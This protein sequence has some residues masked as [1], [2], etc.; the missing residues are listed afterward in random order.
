MDPKKAKKQAHESF[1]L[2]QFTRVSAS[3]PRKFFG[4]SVRAGHFVEM[5]VHRAEKVSD[6]SHISYFARKALINLRLSPNQFSELLTTMNVGMGVPC[7]LQRVAGVD[8][9][10][11]VD[12]DN[13]RELHHKDFMKEIETATKEIREAI[14]EAGEALKTSKASFGIGQRK[15]LLKKLKHVLMRLESNLPYYHSKFDESVDK[16]IGEAKA[17]IDTFAGNVITQLGLDSLET[18]KAIQNTRPDLKAITDGK[19]DEGS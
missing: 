1:G 13:I 4:S 15:E 7:T 9:S 12:E 16:T 18:L 19:D 17:E 2:I 5:T 11:C 14:E 6:G 8:M 3:P 10:E